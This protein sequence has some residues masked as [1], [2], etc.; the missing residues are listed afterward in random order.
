VRP[1]VKGPS[2]EALEALRADARA[3]G[4]DD[5]VILDPLG[6]IV[7]GAATAIAWWRG[8]TLCLPAQE[9]ERVDSVTARALAALATA[10]GTPISWETTGPGELDGHEVWALNALH[11]PR[12]VTTWR[13]GPAMAEQPGRLATWRAR[14][15]ALRKPLAP[16]EAVAAR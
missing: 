4:I 2:L 14:L 13:D 12:I 6:H 3:D 11:G 7:E 9:L 1:T 15:D 5:L 8:E 16:A 10:A